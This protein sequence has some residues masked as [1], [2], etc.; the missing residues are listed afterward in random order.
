[1]SDYSIFVVSKGEEIVYE[2]DDK[3]FCFEMRL[4]QAP[5]QLF[6][7]R[8]WT[9]SPP[10]L[11]YELTEPERQRIIPRLVA[12]LGAYGDEVDIIWKAFHQA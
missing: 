3:Q 11:F 12:Y 10:I 8:Y 7:G 5:I 2:E 6:A 4:S 1:M 9:D